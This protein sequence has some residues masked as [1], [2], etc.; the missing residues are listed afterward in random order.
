MGQ[1]SDE[2][3]TIKNPKISSDNFIFSNDFAN[4]K[5]TYTLNRKT[6]ILESESHNGLGIDLIKYQC[7]KS[8]DESSVLKEIYQLQ[9]KPNKF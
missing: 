5:F 2:I 9:N 6:G 4:R 3:N 8:N 7:E 1:I